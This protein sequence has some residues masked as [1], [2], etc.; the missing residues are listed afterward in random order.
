VSLRFATDGDE[1]AKLGAMVLVD[2][3]PVEASI[4]EALEV[5]Q[6]NLHGNVGLAR[7]TGHCKRRQG[8]RA[9]LAR[10][11][12]SLSLRLA[13]VPPSKPCGGQTARRPGSTSET[14]GMLLVSRT[15]FTC[16]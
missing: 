5:D 7:H 6:V 9:T 12:H 2:Q 10:E 11:I 13:Y 16:P 15:C 1:H 3:E 14:Y 8:R 4:R